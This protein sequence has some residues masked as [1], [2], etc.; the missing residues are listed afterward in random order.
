M[1]RVCDDETYYRQFGVGLTS[2]YTY[3][4]LVF[5][6]TTSVHLLFIHYHE[7]LYKICRTQK[8]KIA[9]EDAEK[10]MSQLAAKLT[11]HWEITTVNRNYAYYEIMNNLYC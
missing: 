5:R 11:Y 3:S 1:N 8:S 9:E 4:G 2:I 7:G 10:Y 6:Y